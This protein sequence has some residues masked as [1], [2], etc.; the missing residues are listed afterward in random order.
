MQPTMSRHI[1]SE[2]HCVLH[3]LVFNYFMSLWRLTKFTWWWWWWWWKMCRQDG[4]SLSSVVLT[5]GLRAVCCCLVL[6]GTVHMCVCVLW[7]LTWQT[8]SA[9]NQTCEDFFQ[10]LGKCV[11]FWVLT[12]VQ[13]PVCVSTCVWSVCMSTCVVCV[14][15]LWVQEYKARQEQR[16]K[17]F[18]ELSEPLITA[19]TLDRLYTGWVSKHT[20][21]TMSVNDVTVSVLSAGGLHWWQFVIGWL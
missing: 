9:L 11:F 21:H 4:C 2:C 8:F 5:F 17:R 7:D 18:G 16:V 3:L 10:V 20:I 13:K 6:L 15:G 14:C 12:T 19:D 1:V